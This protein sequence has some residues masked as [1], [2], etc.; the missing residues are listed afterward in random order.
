MKIEI[1]SKSEAVI[2]GYVNA[3][4]RDSRL[5]PR[6]MCAAANKPFYEQVVPGAFTVALN[7]AKNVE[8]RFNHGK[9][10]AGTEDGTLSLHEDNIGLWAEA[11]IHDEETICKAEK[12]ELR[13]WSFGFISQRDSWEDISE[14]SCR[15]KLEEFELREVSILDKTPAYVGTSVASVEFR[16]E[17]G[18]VIELRSE[19]DEAEV[20]KKPQ[21]KANPCEYY[22]KQIEILSL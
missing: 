20:E 9:T 18:E 6:S 12:G 15:R 22:G 8:L 3:V 7:K 21:G 17:G 16:E 4:A 13:G 10:I 19:E 2:S 1:R 11:T 5:L 14:E